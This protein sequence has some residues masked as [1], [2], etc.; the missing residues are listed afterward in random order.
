[1][2]LIDTEAHKYHYRELQ[3]NMYGTPNPKYGQNDN[4]S[5]SLDT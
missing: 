5:P 2:W 4:H 3:D 1:M